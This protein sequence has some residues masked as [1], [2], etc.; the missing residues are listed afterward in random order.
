MKNSTD[1][2]AANLRLK[3]LKARCSIIQRGDRLCLRG[4]FPAKPT[5]A[6]QDWHRQLIFLGINATHAGIKF[7]ENEAI[8]LSMALDQSLFDWNVYLKKDE[9]SLS[10]TDW[11]EKFKEHKLAQGIKQQTWKTGYAIALK[12]LKDF[13]EDNAKK[14]VFSTTANSRNRQRF[15]IAIEAFFKFVGHEISLKPYKGNYS[16]SKVEPRNIPTDE[17]IQSTFYKIPNREYQWAYGILATYGIRPEEITELE[18]DAMPILICHGDKSESSDRRIYPFYPEWV[19]LFDLKNP[20]LKPKVNTAKYINVA[21]R[22]YHLSFTP[23][24]L[25]HA[26]AIRTMEMGLNIEL[27]AAQMGHSVKVH[28]ETYHRWISDRHHQKAFDAIMQKHD[29]LKPPERRQSE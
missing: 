3:S 20:K 25:R 9:E 24:D 8:K 28:S 10:Y 29:R 6:R 14:L 2:I 19:E 22:R 15:C 17:I 27:S 18:F 21:F 23:Y 1:I 11:V 4:T 16:P 13:D 7:A 5:A 26:W 12:Q